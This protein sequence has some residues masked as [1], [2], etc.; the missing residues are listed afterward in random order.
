[1]KGVRFQRLARRELADAVAYYDGE[2]A[3]LGQEFLDELEH[4]IGLL[5]RFPQVGSSVRGRLRR[6]VL[7]R[8]P[9]YLI[10]RTLGAGRLRILAVAHQAREP[11]Y[12][13]GR[14]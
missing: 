8:F 11:S 10:Y 2:R 14:Q 4:A 9:Y 12:W 3:G 13:V 6:L 7:P 1:M 5:Q